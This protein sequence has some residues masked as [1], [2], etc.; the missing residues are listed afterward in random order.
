M[1]AGCTRREADSASFHRLVWLDQRGSK[2]P[3]VHEAPPGAIGPGDGGNRIAWQEEAATGAN[4]A[5]DG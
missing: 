2:R 1:A 5:G 4:G 3:A